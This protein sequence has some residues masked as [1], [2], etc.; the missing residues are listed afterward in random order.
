MILDTVERIAVQRRSQKGKERR[1]I[2]RALKGRA[3]RNDFSTGFPQAASPNPPESE[4]TSDPENEARFARGFVI[5]A[6]TGASSLGA[7]G[8]SL[9]GTG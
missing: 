4:R 7:F 3:T 2:Y 6:L 8:S 9:P 1:N 5:R